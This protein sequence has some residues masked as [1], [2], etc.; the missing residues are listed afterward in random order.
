MRPPRHSPSAS[1]SGT[2]PC[3]RRSSTV[4]SGLGTTL[5]LARELDRAAV[6]LEAGLALFREIGHRRG[7][8]S[9]ST[10]SR[11]P[12]S[13]KAMPAGRL[14]TCARRRRS[15]GRQPCTRTRSP[16]RGVAPASPCRRATAY[17]RRACWQRL[18]RRARRRAWS[19]H[20]TGPSTDDGS[21][22]YA[23]P[24]ATPF[25]RGRGTPARVPRWRSPR[26]WRSRDARARARQARDRHPSAVLVLRP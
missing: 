19:S 1:C 5:R 22:L 10:A 12:R 9:R 4:V 13:S 17:L 20:P 24:S 6:L 11:T 21:P 8:R 14:H 26:R 2:G 23:R 3:S 15:H 18:S 25:F 7:A 16:A